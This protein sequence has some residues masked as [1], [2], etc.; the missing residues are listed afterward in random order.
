[1]RLLVRLN[2]MCALWNQRQQGSSKA[3]DEP[4]AKGDTQHAL[5]LIVKGRELGTW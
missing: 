5:G 1:M 2:A 4:P 3:K